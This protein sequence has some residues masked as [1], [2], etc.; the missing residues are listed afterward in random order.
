MRVRPSASGTALVT[1]ASSGIG[2][3][4]ARALADRGHNLTLVARREDRLQSLAA[5]LTD[6]VRVD[7]IACDLAEAN[8]RARLFDAIAD[9]G[10]TLDI[11][12]NN[13]GIGTIGPVAQT[14]VNRELA[15]VRL[16]VEAVIDLTT[17]AVAPMVAAG[18]GAILNI[19]SVSG[20][21]PNPGMA[22]YAGT[23]AFVYLYGESLR[24]ELAGTGV[25]VTTVCPGPVRTEF[26]A[27]AGAGPD[28]LIY[29]EYMYTPVEDVAQVAIEALGAGRGAVIT[30]RTMRIMTSALR[31]LP[32]DLT[33][34]L[35][36]RMGG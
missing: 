27:A 14:S 36:A 25:S 12:V 15:L 21:F 2:A 9:L 18:R 26:V 6:R 31:I 1:G 17:R 19:G 29:P 13:A 28:A 20:F 16:N 11:L 30:G 32:N 22:G 35:L 33:M 5:E 24:G 7:V 8:Q 3:E 34:R 4:I 23:K 10:L